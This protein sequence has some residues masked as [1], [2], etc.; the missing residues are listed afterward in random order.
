MTPLEVRQSRTPSPSGEDPLDSTYAI[1]AHAILSED[2]VARY[3]A[4]PC[5]RPATIVLP[6]PPQVPYSNLNASQNEHIYEIANDG[7]RAMRSSHH[8]RKCE[9]DL[10]ASTTRHILIIVSIVVAAGIFYVVMA[11]EGKMSWHDAGKNEEKIVTLV[12]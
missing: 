7:E 9:I 6:P 5:R 2:E 10:C 3:V 11:S 12:P 1:P 8:T 4:L